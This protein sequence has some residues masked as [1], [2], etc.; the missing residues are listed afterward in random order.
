MRDFNQAAQ[1]SQKTGTDNTPEMKVQGILFGAK[2]QGVIDQ[3]VYGTRLA[4]DHVL[5]ELETRYGTV[6][7]QWL[8]EQMP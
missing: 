2:A 5:H 3:L 6:M 7:A 4:N 8:M 1:K